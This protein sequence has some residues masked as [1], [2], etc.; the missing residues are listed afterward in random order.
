MA[1]RQQSKASQP[2]QELISDNKAFL[3][4]RR[5]LGGLLVVIG[6][7]G[8]T[9]REQLPGYRDQIVTDE[10]E[11]GPSP[12]EKEQQLREARQNQRLTLVPSFGYEPVTEQTDDATVPVSRIS[13]APNASGNGDRIRCTVASGFTDEFIELLVALWANPDQKRNQ[14]ET[15]VGGSSLEFEVIPGDNIWI[16]IAIQPAEQTNRDHP[17]LAKLRTS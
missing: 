9:F 10:G 5:T 12:W 4:R 13:A 11:V 17:S 14:Y 6:V 7:A 15:S 16:G 3:S 1:D 8:W 2:V